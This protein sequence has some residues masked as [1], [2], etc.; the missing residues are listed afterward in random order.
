MIEGQNDVDEAAKADVEEEVVEVDSVPP[1]ASGKK[2][3]ASGTTDPL[4]G[5]VIHDRFR[6][7]APIARGGMGAV[8]KAEQA[9]LGR[10]VAIKVLSPK[11]DEEKDPEFRKRFFLE[12]ATVAK[13]SHPNTVTV[14]DY[15]QS[16]GLFFIVMELLEGH[17]LKRVMKKEG[18]FGATRAVHITKQIC[19]SLREAHRLGV[20]HR[21][22]KPG[23]VM[24]LNQGDEKDYVKVLDFGLV[25]DIDKEDDDEDLT[26]AGVFMG[27]PKYMSPEQIQGDHVD[28]RSDIYALG[29]LLYE[30]LTGHPPF[31]RD[32]QVQVLMDHINAAPPPMTVPE[33][34]PP[35]PQEL[36]QVTLK[37]LA[38]KREDR[39]DDMEQFLVALK[40]VAGDLS[41]PLP[42]SGELGLT[43]E[44][45]IPNGTPVSGIHALQNDPMRTSSS[46]SLSAPQL[47]T[48]TS[49]PI[50]GVSGSHVTASTSQSLADE[51][52][53]NKMVMVLGALAML[54]AAAILFFVLDPLGTND[55]DPLPD[56]PPVAADPDPDPTPVVEAPDPPPVENPQVDPNPTPPEPAIASVI[57]ELDSDPPGA[58]VRVGEQSYG[59]TP[60]QVELTGDVASPGHEVSFVFTLNGHRDYTISRNVPAEGPLEVTARMRRNWRPRTNDD[61]GPGTDVNLPGYR[62]TPY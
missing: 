45:Q 29:V 31:Q 5:K 62:D 56:P 53:G 17:T 46:G 14:F 10:L 49:G 30:M 1:A 15:G 55:P 13:L 35:I 41:L 58:M 7:I 59:P 52:P 8:Y 16:E 18:P 3:K 6:I 38:K 21:D 32:K 33:G 50:P 47:S 39:F 48:S 60:T 26:Q 22:M 37:C 19:R 54:A 40:M 4:V 36:Q 24:L 34:K 2:D 9:P 12:A 44:F 28:G 11:H 61:D 57:I 23:N 25:K 42:P 20:I 43:G 51:S 27:S